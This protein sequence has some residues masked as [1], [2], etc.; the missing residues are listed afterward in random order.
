MRIAKLI[1]VGSLA[2]LVLVAAPALAKNSDGQ[3]TDDKQASAPSLPAGPRW[4]MDAIAM[5]RDGRVWAFCRDCRERPA[6]G[7]VFRLRSD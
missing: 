5:R 2:A 3:K 7:G 1:F 6:I 4:I